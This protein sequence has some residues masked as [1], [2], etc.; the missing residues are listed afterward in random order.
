VE[1]P[2]AEQHPSSIWI[3]H[4]WADD[5]GGNFDYVISR[6]E[7]VGV[8]AHYDRRDLVHGLPLWPQ[9]EDRITKDP[10]QGWGIILTRNSLS[11]TKCREELNYALDRALEARGQQFKLI[12]LL[13]GD[14]SKADVPAALRTRLYV[15]LAG[16]GWPRLVRKGLEEEA[17]GGVAPFVSE[18]V[19]T[20]YQKY[21]RSPTAPP[22][23]AIE[24]RPRY[25]QI[26]AWIFLVPPGTEVV[27]CAPG[28]A[29]GAP[30]N[31]LRMNCS[32][33]SPT[34]TGVVTDGPMAGTKFEYFGAA[35]A[36]SVSRSAYVVF[37]HGFPAFVGFSPVPE[38]GPAGFPRGGLEV[39]SP[40]EGR[41]LIHPLPS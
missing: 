35:D 25:G 12:G 9:I 18:Y 13:D 28:S 1:E 21:K 8:E 31:Q 33:P 37:T 4:A 20:V 38:S 16:A 32:P 36:L 11:S 26:G 41:F 5:V 3:T 34:Q 23:P 2:V 10:I 39:M 24:V 22:L 29:G 6:L 27:D 7:A 15:N 40:S 19:W 14:V 17:L 30:L